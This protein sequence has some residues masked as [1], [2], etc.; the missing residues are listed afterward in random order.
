MN[1]KIKSKSL[2]ADRHI[3][4]FIWSNYGVVLQMSEEKFMK[5]PVTDGE[6]ATFY[7]NQAHYLN[8]KAL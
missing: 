2:T 3:K 5:T 4:K 8:R 1:E 6:R 7:L